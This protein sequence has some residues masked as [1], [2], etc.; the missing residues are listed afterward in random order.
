[1]KRP[2]HISDTYFFVFLS[3]SYVLVI[4]SDVISSCYKLRNVENSV[5]VSQ[6]NLS[7]VAVS[8]TVYQCIL[9]HYKNIYK[10]VGW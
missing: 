7:V 5:S 6:V 2:Y 1:M 8:R 10:L 9:L 3:N 4:R